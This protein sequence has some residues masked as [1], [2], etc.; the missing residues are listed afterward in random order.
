MPFGS[1]LQVDIEVWSGTDCNMGYGVGMYWYGD[2]A[3]T[4][5]RKP[6]PKEARNVPPLPDMT[7]E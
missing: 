5:N 6:D 3:T 2:A 7:K 1:S 4:S